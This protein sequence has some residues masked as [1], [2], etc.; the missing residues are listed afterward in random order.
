MLTLCIKKLPKYL[1]EK[2]N[3]SL[4]TK[5]KFTAKPIWCKNERV[6]GLNDMAKSALGFHTKISKIKVEFSTKSSARTWLSCSSGRSFGP[7]SLRLCTAL[8]VT[9]TLF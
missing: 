3:H 6:S 4:Q 2:G 7:W 1:T 9:T 5:S 8:K